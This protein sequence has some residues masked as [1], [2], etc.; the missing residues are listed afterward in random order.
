M[1]V[2]PVMSEAK[3]DARHGLWDIRES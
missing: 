1:F 2:A 3:V